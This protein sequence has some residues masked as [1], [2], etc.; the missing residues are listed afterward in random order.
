MT[1]V[2]I[3]G[4]GIA[5]LSAA[6]YL[7]HDRDLGAKEIELTLVEASARLGGALHTKKMEG[8]VVEHGSDSFITSK[9]M[10][11]N[12]CFDLGLQDQIV[13]TNEVN[14]R[15][16]IASNGR[17]VAVP[18]GF[19]L[20]APT[21]FWPFATSPLMSLGGKLRAGLELFLPPS[22]KAEDESVAGFVQR[23]FG[24]ELLEKVAQPLVG[25]IYTGDVNILSARSTLA[26]FM[27]LERTYG[28]VIKGLLQ[29]EDDQARTA[30]G[31][32]YH[33]FNSLRDGV[34]SLIDALFNELSPN[35]VHLNTCAQCLRANSNGHWS[36][37]FS[38]G[39]A[40]NANAVVLA[41]SAHQAAA[42][43]RSVDSD[44][45]ASL[46]EIENSSAIVINF[47]F[48]QDDLPD[49]LEGFGFVVPEIEQR[50]I[51]ACSFISAKFVNRAPKGTVS[52]RVFLG[53]SLNHD[54]MLL[55]DDHLVSMSLH[56]LQSYLQTKAEPVQHWLKRWP[57]SMPQYKVGHG[58]L[59][60]KIRK[61]MQSYPT[62]ALAG[63]SYDGVGIPDC[64]QSGYDAACKIVNSIKVRDLLSK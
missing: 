27:D 41:I 52:M 25:G 4:G 31:A 2:V 22:A 11:T 13:S 17:L 34:G 35:Q 3:I 61:R 48:E 21:R 32:R 20:I 55:D 53:G 60:D 54:L 49:D 9:P 8:F 39:S 59:I 58:A 6:H 44:L 10:A 47:L 51:L 29:E 42:L 36:V 63:N 26:H 18:D 12:L 40:L 38:D 64:I 33:I 15:S 45:S 28:S 16:L 56:E 62:L 19:R 5:G 24:R 43:V 37:I 1:K 7:L 50:S 30:S 57:S 46:E 14:R 23:R